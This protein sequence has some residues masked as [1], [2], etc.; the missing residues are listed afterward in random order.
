MMDSLSCLE[1]RGEPESSEPCK[2]KQSDRVTGEQR[3]DQSLESH[4][5]LCLAA[6]VTEDHRTEQPASS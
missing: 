3:A 4:I 5:K 1:C 6:E 2:V